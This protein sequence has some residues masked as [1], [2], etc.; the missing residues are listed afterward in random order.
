MQYRLSDLFTPRK[1]ACTPSMRPRKQ[2]D[3]VC[4][5]VLLEGEGWT[6]ICIAEVAVPA[7][8]TWMDFSSLYSNSRSTSVYFGFTGCDSSGF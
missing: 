6:M 1:E 3:T 2:Y 8:E 7:N 5:Y 4:C